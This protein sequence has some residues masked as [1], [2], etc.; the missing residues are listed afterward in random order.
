M[1]TTTVISKESALNI[2]K[3]RK[4]VNAPG[5]YKNVKVTQINAVSLMNSTAR[6]AL[7]AR[8]VTHIANFN[9]ATNYQVLQSLT[10]FKSGDYNAAVNQQMSSSIRKS[11]YCPSKSEYVDVQVGEIVN[12]D[13]ET[14]L[15]I[16]SIMPAK[17]IEAQAIDMSMFDDDATVATKQDA[18]LTPLENEAF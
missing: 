16:Q 18:D 17:A 3:S 8:N 10:A 12:K 14:I 11:D 7:E 9:L 13:G 6:T 2:I 15:V 1:A 5:L 4:V